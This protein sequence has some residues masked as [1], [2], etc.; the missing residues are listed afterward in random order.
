MNIEYVQPMKVEIHS[1]GEKG[2]N[3]DET[4]LLSFL[5]GSVMRGVASSSS[6]AHELQSNRAAGL[7]HLLRLQRDPMAS[8]SASVKILSRDCISHHDEHQNDGYV[9]LASLI[10]DGCNAGA[11][12][13]TSS[14]SRFHVVPLDVLFNFGR[15]I[16]NTTRSDSKFMQT[17][18]TCSEEERRSS[19]MHK[20]AD[21]PFPLCLTVD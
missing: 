21:R 14:E 18:R 20:T 12:S 2:E 13:P 11:S 1:Q 15:R 9:S 16:S 19:S 7:T 4:D 5:R 10:T 6:F 3:R 17:S 8:N